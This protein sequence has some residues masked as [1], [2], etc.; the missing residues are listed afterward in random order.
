MPEEGKKRKRRRGPVPSFLLSPASMRSH[1]DRLE[2]KKKGGEVKNQLAIPHFQ[3]AEPEKKEGERGREKK[4][5]LPL[6]NFS[7]GSMPKEKGK[8]EKETLTPLL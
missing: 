3:S 1:R 8:V 4:P 7:L 2:G 5:L 6:P